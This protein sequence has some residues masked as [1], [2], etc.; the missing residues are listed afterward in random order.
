MA[1]TM[2]RACVAGAAS[3]S[4]TVRVCAAKQD[5]PKL[6]SLAAGVAAAVLLSVAPANAGVIMEQPQLKKVLQD[7]SPSAPAPKREIILPGMR[8][9]AAP[10][11]KDAAA[12]KAKATPKPSVTSGGDL[13]PRSVALPGTLALIAGGAFALTKVDEGFEEFMGEASCKDSGLDGA[14]YETALKGG[15]IAARKPAAGTK[16][17]KA[18]AGKGSKAGT[19]KSS[20]LASFFDK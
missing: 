15:A 2:K 16:K 11:T 7:D 4:R 18:A 13:D 10:A 20:P 8:S 19:A 5:A 3:R 1:V 6:Q 9:K 14:G 17:V 12:P